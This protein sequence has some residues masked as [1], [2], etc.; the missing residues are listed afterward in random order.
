MSHVDTSPGGIKRV[1]QGLADAWAS[2]LGRDVT[3]II[4]ANEAAAALIRVLAIQRDLAVVQKGTAESL[5]L[6]V[7][8]AL[9]A[10]LA[11]SRSYGGPS[12]GERDIEQQLK[13]AEA[14]LTAVDAAARSCK[15]AICGAP[16]GCQRK[17]CKVPRAAGHAPIPAQALATAARDLAAALTALWPKGVGLGDIDKALDGLRSALAA[18]PPKP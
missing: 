16:T 2:D 3:P 5:A 18:V 6:G 17:D 15:N 12:P 10:D 14:V 11:L 4:D 8:T 9:R 13:G 1:L 7:V